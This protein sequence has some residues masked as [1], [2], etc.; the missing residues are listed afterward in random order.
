[1]KFLFRPVLSLIF[2]FS[3]NSVFAAKVDTV[4]TF[5]AAMNKKIKAVIITPEN[6][7]TG[8]EFPVVYLLHGAGGNYGSWLKVTKKLSD[9]AD[10]YNLI[11]ACPDGS[12]TS[13]Y[14]DSPVDKTYRYET[15]VADE[16]VKWVDKNYKTI[17]DR[18]G[19]AITGLS[20][21]GHGGLYLSFRHQDVFGAAGSMSGGVDFRPF[22][23]NWD[24]AKRLGTY[25]SNP[26]N[27]E[28]NT[29]INMVH[30]LTPKSLALIIDCGTEDFFFRV[31]ENLHQKLLERNIPHDYIIRPGAHNG[32]YW[33]NAVHYQLLYMSKFFNRKS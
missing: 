22:P 23:N 21:G 26:E 33:A 7:S 4:E 31:N 2:L 29:V 18:S 16:L 5:S 13:W 24:I 1:M 11:I 28:Q 32:D 15:Y 27:W 6:Y 12:K 8:K 30:L 9:Y 3:I 20:M 14:F 10:Q 19:R 25:A 17:K